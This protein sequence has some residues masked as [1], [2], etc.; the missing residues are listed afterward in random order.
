VEATQTQQYGIR[1][2]STEARGRES[3]RL[4][5]RVAGP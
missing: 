2:A 5:C 4:P 3:W 1:K